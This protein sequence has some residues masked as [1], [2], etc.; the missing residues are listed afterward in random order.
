MSQLESLIASAGESE[1]LD[2][3]S[4]QLPPSNTSVTTRK[5]ACRAYPQGLTSLCPAG[6]KHTRIKLAGTEWVDT[7][8]VRMV[9]TIKNEDSNHKLVP[10][11]GGWGALQQVF[12]RSNG[13]ELD[14]IQYFNRYVQQFLWNQSDMATQWGWLGIESGYSSVPVGGNQPFRP[15]PVTIPAGGSLTVMFQIG[16][17]HV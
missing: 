11:C 7:P 4:Y 12:L 10:L 6:T 3:L 2:S 8:T 16:R 5:N 9:F 14:N 1:L 17:A 13:V 15:K